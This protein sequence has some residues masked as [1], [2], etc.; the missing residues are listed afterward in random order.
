MSVH[1]RLARDEHL[2]ADERHATQSAWL[3][4]LVEHAYA[5]APAVRTLLDEAGLLPTAVR[6]VTDLGQVPIVRKD[7]LIDLQRERPPFGGFLGMPV[8]QLAR[9]F[10][11]PGPLHDPQG[12]APDYWRWAKPLRAAGF[13]SG[14]VV[15]NACAYHLTPL[16]FM[17]DEAARAI[18][19]RVIPSGTGNTELQIGAAR[20]LG[21]TAYCGT[22][23]FL[24]II[25]DKAVEVGLEPTTH[26]SLRR[27]FVAGEMLPESLR[28]SIQALG[29]TVR[30]GYGTADLGCLGYE[31]V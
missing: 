29:I 5:N 26:L 2:S 15:L 21:A 23:S 3:A 28:A 18:G 1:A 25:L 19:C 24:R 16:G 17:F 30:Q 8:E 22:P 6:S 27:A 12:P 11:S 20:A 13:E 31:C 4:R 9:I 7:A 14:D 10:V